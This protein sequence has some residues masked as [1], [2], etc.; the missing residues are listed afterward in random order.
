[1]DRAILCVRNPIDTIIDVA[2]YTLLGEV[3][4]SLTPGEFQTHQKGW[5]AFIQQEIGV[6]S[7]F[8]T[9]WTQA[10]IPV[11]IIRLEDIDRDPTAVLSE[12]MKF[13]LNTKSI[14]GRV[15]QKYIDLFA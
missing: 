9:F 4:R 1:V 8:H 6:W 3:G 15:I 13:L 12:A 11:H 14:E 5:S 7:N 2:N 10:K